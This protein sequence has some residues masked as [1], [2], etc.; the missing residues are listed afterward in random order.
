MRLAFVLLDDPSNIEWAALAAALERAG[1]EPGDDPGGGDA[2]SVTVDG[3]FVQI[4][5][6]PAPVPDQEAEEHAAFSVGNLSGEWTPP[7]HR[8]HLIVTGKVDDA[9][10]FDQ[11]VL[12]TGVL[13]AI[14]DATPAVA[15]YW[16]DAGATHPPQFFRDVAEDAPILLW[17]G[18]SVARPAEDRISLLS[19]GMQSQFDLPDVQLDGPSDDA[20]ELMDFFLDLLG[21]VAERDEP[22]GEGETVG[23]DNDERIPIRYI[24]SPIDGDTEIAHIHFPA[25]S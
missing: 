4:G 10:A 2:L 13:V 19:L 12:F 9:P 3:G 16:G 15:V 5:L 8:A 6:I 24:P 17:T 18:V 11:L 23:R 22:F 1:Y 7:A 21:Y 25:P 14:V 20:S